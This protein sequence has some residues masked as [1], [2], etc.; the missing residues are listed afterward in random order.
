MGMF[1]K[2]PP[3]LPA[4][5][6]DKIATAQAMREAARLKQEQQLGGRKEDDPVMTLIIT[7]IVGVVLAFIITEGGIKLPA[8]IE[9]FGGTL[10]DKVLFGSSIPSLWGSPDVDKILTIFIR[11]FFIFLAAGIVPGATMLFKKM[12]DKVNINPLVL[13]WCMTV[14]VPVLIFGVTEVVPVIFEIFSFF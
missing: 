8:G 5:A 6:R 10:L 1:S 9:I 11:G 14:V 3:P 12:V 2:E 4:G 7:Y 13:C